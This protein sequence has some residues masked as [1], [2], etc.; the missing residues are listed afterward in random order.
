M[1]AGVDA[2]AA[3]FAFGRLAESGVAA[4]AEIAETAPD[5]WSFD[6]LTAALRDETRRVFAAWPGGQPGAPVAFAV[7]CAAPGGTTADLQI[8]AVAPEW[9]KKGVAKM[10]LR[11]CFG[12]LAQAGVERVLLEMRCSNTAAARLYDALGFKELARRPGMYAHP[13]EDGLLLGRDI[14]PA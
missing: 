4:C 6:D 14:A 13:R 2:G 8:V 11:H 7:F 1:S 3:G 5:V 9:R 12:A 10:L